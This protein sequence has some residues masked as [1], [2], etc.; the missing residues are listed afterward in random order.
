[1]NVIFYVI[2]VQKYEREK[3]LADLNINVSIIQPLQPD[4]SFITFMTSETTH[5]LKFVECIWNKRKTFLEN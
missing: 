2:V 3:F 1:M 5:L 4:G